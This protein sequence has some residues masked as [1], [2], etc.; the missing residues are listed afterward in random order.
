MVWEAGGRKLTGLPDGD[1]LLPG[2]CPLAKVASP[3]GFEPR[4]PTVKG[5]CPRPLDDGD[6][7]RGTCM[8]EPVGIE[9]TTSTMPCSALPAELWPHARGREFWGTSC[10]KSNGLALATVEIPY[11]LHKVQWCISLNLLDLP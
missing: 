7:V 2:E 1:T 11:T 9:P 8:V 10:A 6:N 5:S 4:S 3:R